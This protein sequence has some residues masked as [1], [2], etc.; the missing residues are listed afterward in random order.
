MP[1]C[2]RRLS[3][4][5][6]YH[7]MV[8]GNERKNI[9]HD[10][11]DKVRFL[12]TLERMRGNR[13][14][15]IYAYCLMSNHA[16]LLVK[17]VNETIER[18]MKRIGVSYTYYF[19]KKYN[20]VGHLFQDRFKSEP[21]ESDAYLLQCIKYIHNNPVKANMAK[22]AEEY[23]WSSYR[24]FVGN[25]YNYRLCKV[26]EILDIY[27]LNRKEELLQL[28]EDT[29]Q[30]SEMSFID[31]SE[32][33]CGNISNKIDIRDILAKYGVDKVLLREMKDKKHRDLIIREIKE[34]TQKS[35]SEL[36]SEL[37]LS[38]DIVFRALK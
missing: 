10:S 24:E 5:S 15:D 13:E 27:S 2:A 33:P 38:K 20:R 32:T 34:N 36:S 26:D 29:N 14:Y 30:S 23:K 22:S 19:N 25:S 35:I 31:L 9:F 3:E 7:I 18:S 21:I 17:T 6:I 28:I 16:H 4:S 37:N 8:R 11:E 1:R 12:S